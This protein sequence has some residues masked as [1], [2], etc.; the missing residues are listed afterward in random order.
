V[1]LGLIFSFG[2]TKEPLGDSDHRRVYLSS[3]KRAAKSVRIQTLGF[4]D[5]GF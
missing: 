5:L 2:L 1:P 4:S 3:A